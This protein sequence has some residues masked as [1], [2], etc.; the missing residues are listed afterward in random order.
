M[1]RAAILNHG[2]VELYSSIQGF[3]ELWLIDLQFD[4]ACLDPGN[5]KHLHCPN[6]EAQILI[7]PRTS[8]V[9]KVAILNQTVEP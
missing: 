8:V 2:S 5:I 3:L 1:H 9:P 7:Y 4:G 6:H